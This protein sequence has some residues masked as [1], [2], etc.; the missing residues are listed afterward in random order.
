MY[1]T[2]E[3]LNHTLINLLEEPF[4]AITTGQPDYSTDHRINREPGMVDI[5]IEVN[6]VKPEII[7][8]FNNDYNSLGNKFKE[9][10]VQNGFA[11]CQILGGDETNLI[12]EVTTFM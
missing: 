2:I 7:A 9:W 3:T 10:S 5:S 11:D 6:N 4:M 12:F 1:E 8:L